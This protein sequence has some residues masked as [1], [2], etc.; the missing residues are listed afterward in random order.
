MCLL[1]AQT[2]YDVF[3]RTFWQ[4][5]HNYVKARLTGHSLIINAE[6]VCCLPRFHIDYMYSE[7]EMGRV[8]W[9]GVPVEMK[10]CQ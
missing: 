3:N 1:L 7:G 8:T 9:G 5:R 4:I 10:T 2:P 6:R